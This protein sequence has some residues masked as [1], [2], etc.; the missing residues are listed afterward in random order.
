MKVLLPSDVEKVVKL[1]EGYSGSDL[2]AVR[3]VL[4]SNT[5]KLVK[6]LLIIRFVMKL[7]LVQLEKLV[8]LNCAP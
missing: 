4:S 3:K 7:L 8:P 2:S 5:S 1:T 6:H